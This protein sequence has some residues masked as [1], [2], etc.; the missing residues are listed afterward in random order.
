MSNELSIDGI[1]DILKQQISL[2]IIDWRSQ[3]FE[4]LK[5]L[6]EEEIAYYDT[7][8]STYEGFLEE[9]S[10]LN[11]K[12][13]LI[14]YY[15]KLVRSITKKKET[16]GDNLQRSATIFIKGTQEELTKSKIQQN[17]QKVEGLIKELEDIKK[18]Y[19]KS[20]KIYQKERREIYQKER[21]EAMQD[22]QNQYQNAKNDGERFRIKNAA[23]RRGFY[24]GEEQN[25]K[26][27][28]FNWKTGQFIKKNTKGE[29]QVKIAIDKEQYKSTPHSVCSQIVPEHKKTESNIQ[30][31][32]HSKDVSGQ[33]KLQQEWRSS[34]LKYKN[35]GSR[36]MSQAK[37]SKSHPPRVTKKDIDI[38]ESLEEDLKKY[39]ASFC[40]L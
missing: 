7:H 3:Y 31:G 1:V 6:I 38:E 11:S 24:F 34:Q 22:F 19:E 5:S 13:D 2:S 27:V 17:D 4:K 18:E 10:Y 28:P 29:D 40:K 37:Q 8:R 36:F 20:K 33:I 14:K 9:E 23:D 15:I 35:T 16:K 25:I 12:I 32:Q 30:P 21:S 26:E 39:N